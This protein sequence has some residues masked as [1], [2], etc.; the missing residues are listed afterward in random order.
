MYGVGGVVGSVIGGILTE[1]GQIAL[2]F[3]T[4][5]TLGGCIAVIGCLM[6]SNMDAS[7]AEVINMSLW[8]RIK[9]NY[10]EIKTGLKVR[11]FSRSLIYVCLMGA[12]VPS[13]TDY[14]Y[15]YM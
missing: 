6:N 2:C 3:Y 14:Y 12:V 7:A 11:E 8:T 9:H 13:Y 4:L 1:N 5:A 15:Y 10:Q